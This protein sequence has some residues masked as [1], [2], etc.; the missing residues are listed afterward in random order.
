MASRN[1]EDLLH[2]VLQ[3]VIDEVQDSMSVAKIARVVSYDSGEHTASIQPLG[4]DSDGSKSGMI[5]GALVIKS[6]RSGLVAGDTVVAVFVD[7]DIDNFSGSS[8]FTK[9]SDR[10]HDINDAVV[11]GVI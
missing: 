11:V 5:H 6:A 10:K 8:T 4:L 7:G 1:G 3:Q 2:Q 9:A